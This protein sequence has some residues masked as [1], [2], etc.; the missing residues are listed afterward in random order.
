MPSLQYYIHCFKKLKRDHKKGGAPHK[1]ILLLSIIELSERQEISENKILISP[2]LVGKFKSLWAKL[3]NTDHHMIFAL[4]FSHMR[5]EPFWRLV[6]NPGCEKWIQAKGTMRSF[7]NLTTA[8]NYAQIDNDLYKL[9]QSQE[10]REILK[11]T[12]LEK[13]FP[14]YKATFQDTDRTIFD[15]YSDQILEEEPEEY[16][17]RI[18]NLKIELDENAYEEEIFVR[19]GAFKRQ[20]PKIYGNSCAISGLRI[21]STINISMVDACHIVPFCDSYNDTIT[22]GISLCPNLHRAFDRGLISISNDYTVLVNKNFR[23]PKDT[24]YSIRQFEGKS[25]HIPSNSKYAPSFDNLSI[26]RDKFEF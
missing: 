23:E 21:D 26:H 8:V 16:K 24:P 2:E 19:S 7:S 1:P 9:M 14:D 18:L 20:I 4:P 6:A 22:N 10:S 25:I 15:D 11:I 13:Y 12:L 17:K 5:S 3:V